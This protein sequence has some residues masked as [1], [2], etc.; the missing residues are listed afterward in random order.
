MGNIITVPFGWLLG[1]L[2]QFTANYGV[3]MIL[4]TIFV[5]L[6][7]AP[8]TAKSK[9]ASMKMSRISPLVQDIQKRYEG[10][11]QKMNEALQNLYKE[12]GVSMGAGCLWSL[13]PLL[14]LFPLLSIIREPI[15][16]LLHESSENAAKIVEVIK[17]NA[18]NL[19][20]GNEYYSQVA[21]A[22]HISDFAAQIKEAI[23]GISAETLAGINFDF[24]GIDLGLI[25]QWNIFASDW[26]WDWA[27][28]GGA[29]IPL[30]SA[31]TSVLSMF[32]MQKLNNSVV[33]DKNGVH[34]EETAKKSQA[35]Q[36]TNMM[37]WMMPLMSL[38]IGFTVPGG[39]SLYWL[40]QGVVSI[41]LDVILTLHYR[42]VYDAEDA[43]RLQRKMERDREEAERERVRAERRAANPEG[44][45]QNTSKKKL[46]QKQR[47]E[48]DAAR[49]A[50]VKE[51]NA[52]KGIV[53]E[54]KPEVQV[55]SG[56]AERP[57]CKGRNYDPN[58]YAN[59]TEE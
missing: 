35:N 7:L 2:Y 16:Y 49:A 4:F 55:M 31:G 9:K 38:W 52:K 26:A 22:R 33:T 40:V 50:A 13:V 48:E 32:I 18:P 21:A 12:E 41:I 29:V 3:A 11:Q 28:I 1:I 36:S 56:I 23:P 51:Y 14:I 6:I 20:S 10:D 8:I 44:Q 42:K 5:K 47:A 39:L 30:L 45:T 27:H 58:R 54:E 25:P 43:I 17:A 15:V 19:F 57:Y 37:M 46:Q 34:D 53:E 24:F 59:S